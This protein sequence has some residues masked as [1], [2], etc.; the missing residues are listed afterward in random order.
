MTTNGLSVDLPAGK[1]GRVLSGAR[2]TG[3]LH[4]GNYFGA[5]KNWVSLQDEYD[6]FYF[7][8]DVHALTTVE[9]TVGLKQNTREMALDWLAAG[10]D[11]NRS[12]LFIQSRVPEVLEL[13]TYLSMVT[14]MGS[15]QRVP[16]FKEQFRARADSMNYGL[17]GYPV[18]Q[19]ADI[20]IYLANKVPV[21][22]DQVPHVELS[23]EIVRR[24]NGQFGEVFPEP[25]ALLSDTPSIKGTDGDQKM[26]KSLDNH[27][28]LAGT[29]EETAQR[30]MSMVTDPQRARR[31][32]P[33]RPWICNVYALHQIFSDDDYVKSVYD[34]CTNATIGCVDDKR[35][36]ADSINAYFEPFRE[37][38]AEYEKRPDIVEDVLV[39]GTKRARAVAIRTMEEVRE[40]IGFF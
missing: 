12:T 32:D 2:P 38:R 40:R 21:G 14:P 36:L 5:L 29:P 8:A 19:T 10:L 18:L 31:T 25:D 13:H 33:G 35:A 16:S 30:V 4:L 26:S 22:V 28:E 7:V 37:R 27:I 1:K 23:R 11:P 6:C 24:F 9:D 20:I 39:E 17:V 3:R 34:Q 15:L